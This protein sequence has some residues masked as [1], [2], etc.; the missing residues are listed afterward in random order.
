M[1][2]IPQTYYEFVMDFAPYLYVI[3]PDTPDYQSGRAV[4][5]AAFAI[6][7]LYDVYFAERNS[8]V[9]LQIF[10]K[11][12]DL[13]DFIIAQQCTDPN[14]QAYG[15]FRSN[16]NS[17]LYYSID[18]CRAIPALLKAYMLTDYSR[19]SLLDA[20]RL[21]AL[22]FLRN[23][24]N[25]NQQGG[26]ARYVDADNNFDLK[27]DVE[28]LY[29]LIGLKKLIE[30][31]APNILLYQEI[32]EK[33]VGF[34]REGFEN[35]YL[36]FDPSDQKWHRVGLTE[37]EVYDDV[38]AYALLGLNEWEGWSL[39]CRKVYT[40]LNN[41][42]HNKQYPAYNPAICWAGYIDVV[43]RFVA[44]DYYDSVTAGILWRVRR[45]HDMPSYAFSYQVVKRFMDKWMFWG[46]KH[47]DYS[48]VENKYSVIT[49]SWLGSLLVNYAEAPTTRFMQI[50]KSQGEPVTLYPAIEI[51]DSIS[52]GEPIDITAIV[53][54]ARA[55]EI[56]VLEPGYVI[57]DYIIVY[58][59][60]RL[61]PQDKIRFGG[62]D[63]EVLTCEQFSWRGDPHYFKATCRRMVAQ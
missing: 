25:Q 63:Y 36:W 10:S 4:S 30:I 26:F 38:F 58:T 3:P 2:E 39:S 1:G 60:A 52:Y 56:A 62:L 15:G 20:C 34:L 14:K 44:C 21:A 50:V 5:S 8:T 17:Q 16:E 45:I 24:Q 46:V 18:A 48:P 9:K 23:M 61:R 55:D 37:N 53:N 11:I 31:D 51:G 35:L 43:S 40:A 12:L 27:M 7:F 42:R 59:Y 32:A 41:A 57:N 13:A 54:V 6:E 47:K 22:T 49:V 29:G 33:L 19:N 28:C